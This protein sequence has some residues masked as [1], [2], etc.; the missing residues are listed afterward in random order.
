MPKLFGTDGIRGR[1]GQWPLCDEIVSKVG[2]SSAIAAVRFYTNREKVVL[3]GRDTRGSGKV[4]L[5]DLATGLKSAG[6]TVV[7]LGII[8]TPAVAFLTKDSG[9]VMGV[10]ITASHNSAEFNGIKLISPTGEKVSDEIETWIEDLTD[11]L[12]TMPKIASTRGKVVDGKR[13]VKR[14]KSHAHKKFKGFVKPLSIVIDCA[15]GAAYKIAPEI[16]SSLGAKIRVICNVPDGKNINRACGSLYPD[17]LRSAVV[18]EHADLGLAFDGDGDRL[19]VVN[20]AGEL[21]NGDH[22]LYLIA[23]DYAQR[24]L[25]NK[26]MVII[27]HMANTGL[28]EKLEE[29][30]ISTVR[31]RVGDRYVGEG[32]KSTGAVLG[33]EPVGHIILRRHLPTGDGIIT[34]LQILKIIGDKPDILEDVVR[35]IPQY[36]LVLVNVPVKRKMEDGEMMTH[37][38]RCV[39]ERQEKLLGNPHR[40][41]VRPSGTE[42]YIR[43]MVEA[44]DRVKVQTAAESIAVA[45]K[46]TII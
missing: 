18:A 14:Y 34:A 38:V 25:L 23:R 44:K 3:I 10:S 7:D 16:I 37:E 43:V 9:A 31:V 1:V 2:Y 5:R 29:H 20:S 42:P 8:T 41:N 4:L 22:L 30:G 39:V 36:P 26:N 21:V 33:G 6:L 15:N 12:A 32:M 24:K 19:I 40:I 27:T 11:K 46:K 17:K 28:V 13:Y 45:I 35:D